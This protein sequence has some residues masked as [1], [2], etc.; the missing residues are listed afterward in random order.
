MTTEDE[1]QTPEELLATMLVPVPDPIPDDHPYPEQVEACTRDLSL[2]RACLRQFSRGETKARVDARAGEKRMLAEL[3]DLARVYAIATHSGIR[4]QLIEH[5]RL[6]PGASSRECL[7]AYARLIQEGDAAAAEIKRLRAQ[8]EVDRKKAEARQRDALVAQA[9]AG[10]RITPAEARHWR[11][12]PLATVAAY[13]AQVQ[14][15]AIPSHVHLEPGSGAGSG[16]PT[17][18]GKTYADMTGPERHELHSA[19][20]ELFRIMR[21]AWQSAGR[22]AGEVSS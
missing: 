20:P 16:Q 5:G 12:Q 7:E 4:A 9:R 17:H 13:L 2:Y 22:P 10:N 8:Q 11:T 19:D 6:E 1:E 15:M 18:R 21:S 3:D 14:G